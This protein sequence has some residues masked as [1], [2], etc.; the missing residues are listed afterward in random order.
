MWMTSGWSRR[1]DPASRCEQLREEHFFDSSYCCV[2]ARGCLESVGCALKHACSFAEVMWRLEVSSDG[3]TWTLAD[4]RV[5]LQ[6]V[7][8][9]RR[10][11]AAFGSPEEL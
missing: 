6:P 10:R 2:L 9:Y 1:V 5:T 4:A 3:V 7:T 11:I 8:Y